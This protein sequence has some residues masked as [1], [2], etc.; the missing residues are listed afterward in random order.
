[1]MLVVLLLIAWVAAGAVLMLTGR[2]GYTMNSTAPRWA[3]FLA[4]GSTLMIAL[5]LYVY[6]CIID[7]DI[8]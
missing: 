6:V 4:T 1:M 8:H 7:R 5:P 2:A 3:H